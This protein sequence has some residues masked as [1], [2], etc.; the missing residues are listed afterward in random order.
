[1]SNVVAYNCSCLFDLKVIIEA[2]CNEKFA[3]EPW[4]T[5]TNKFFIF[6][7]YTERVFSFGV[8]LRS[9]DSDFL[10]EVSQ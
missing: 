4:K 2:L 1:M 6:C 7:I 8:I 5:S 10:G 3:N 9:V